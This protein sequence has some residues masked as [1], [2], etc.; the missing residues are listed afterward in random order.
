MAPV[1]KNLRYLLEIYTQCDLSGSRYLAG[2]HWYCCMAGSVLIGQGCC[3]IGCYVFWMW[4]NNE[5]EGGN[6]SLL[7]GKNQNLEGLIRAAKQL[8][9]N[10][11]VWAKV[12][13]QII[14]CCVRTVLSSPK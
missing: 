1:L 4:G 5:T 11:R 12:K 6:G 10:S 13:I 14:L 9:A 7:G 8:K 2:V 3:H